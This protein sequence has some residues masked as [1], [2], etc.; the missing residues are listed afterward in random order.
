VRSALKCL[1][2]T[3]YADRIRRRRAVERGSY[4]LQTV[5]NGSK[6][7]LTVAQR[8]PAVARSAGDDDSIVKEQPRPQYATPHPDHSRAHIHWCCC[9]NAA[10][11]AHQ[12]KDFFAKNLTCRSRCS[13]EL[14]T[15]VSRP[16]GVARTASSRC[17]PLP[18]L[19]PR[20][21][22][23]QFKSMAA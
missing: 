14:I 9:A 22:L 21:F 12:I 19:Y 23:S 6:R 4:R 11:P 16:F 8:T 3:G 5:P 13:S 10:P 18:S 7:L 15:S 17:R 1:F 2:Q 20:V